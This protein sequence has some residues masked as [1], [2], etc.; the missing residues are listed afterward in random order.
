MNRG[1]GQ[2]LGSDAFRGREQFRGKDT[3][4]LQTVLFVTMLFGPE[5]QAS[6]Q[7][8]ANRIGPGDILEIRIAAGLDQD[9]VV[10]FP[11]RVDDAGTACLPE[12]GQ[13]PLAGSQLAEAEKAIIKACI[14]QGL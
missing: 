12:I 5:L 7:L 11:V 9:W 1:G 6:E 4:N 10:Q 13:L 2:W 3:M 8:S 14:H